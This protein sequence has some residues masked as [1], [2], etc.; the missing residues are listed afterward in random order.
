MKRPYI[1]KSEATQSIEK[2][3]SDDE[4][5][6]YDKRIVNTVTMFRRFV[7][8]WGWNAEKIADVCHAKVDD[9]INPLPVKYGDDVLD[10]VYADYVKDK[11]GAENGDIEA[12]IRNRFA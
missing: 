12:V 3:N 1:R 7:E 11:E 8:I 5:G 2:T 6:V 10:F 9:I 4:T